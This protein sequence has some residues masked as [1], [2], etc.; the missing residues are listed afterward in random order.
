MDRRALA[1]ASSSR[2][3]R[4]RVT[5]VTNVTNVTKV[6][7]ATKQPS[8]SST[9]LDGAAR[10]PRFIRSKI[11]EWPAEQL[12]ARPAVCVLGPGLLFL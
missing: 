11:D 7:K 1:R 8:V 5:E 3:A 10:D 6:T 4:S 2:S 9:W 12:D